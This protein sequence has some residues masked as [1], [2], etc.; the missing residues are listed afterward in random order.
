MQYE[1]TFDIYFSITYLSLDTLYKQLLVCFIVYS[2]PEPNIFGLKN[3][4]YV[5]VN[6]G[7]HHMMFLT[8]AIE[9][10]CYIRYSSFN[11]P[12]LWSRT[13]LRLS[14]SDMFKQWV[15]F[16]QNCT[17]YSM[18]H[19]MCSTFVLFWMYQQVLGIRMIDL[20]TSFIM[21]TLTPLKSRNIN[22]KRRKCWTQFSD[23]FAPFFSKTSLL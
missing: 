17:I 22:I 5:I 18:T 8:I 3:V 15:Y 10:N 21:R 12:N 14:K 4:S 6:Q 7:L 20:P 16:M 19:T 23:V 9:M 13:P 1:Y 11:P 2:L